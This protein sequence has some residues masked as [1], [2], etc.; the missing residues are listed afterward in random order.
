M[1][2]QQILIA[3][4]GGG[5]KTRA[6]AFDRS[7]RALAEKIAGPSNHLGNERALVRDSLAEVIDGVLTATGRTRED[8][9]T[10]S[11]GYAGVD[12]DGN[13]ED[14]MREILAEIGITECV[15]RG[16]MVIAHEGALRGGSGV[17]ALAGTGASYLGRSESGEVAKLGGWGYLFGDE[18]SAYWIGASALRAVSQQQDGRGPETLLTAMV[19]DIYGVKDFAQ[20]VPCVYQPN[21]DRRDIACLSRIV[22]EAAEAGD[23]VARR[24]LEEAG[25]ELAR[26]AEALIHRL[27]IQSGCEVSYQGS[28]LK[29]GR[30]VRERFEAALKLSVPQ[31][32]VVAPAAPPVYGAYS[33]GCHAVGWEVKWNVL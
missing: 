2:S 17:L 25:D 15:V 16:D 21:A 3:I 10:V 31:A 19:C 28:V 32:R 14:A 26:G 27:K 33:I 30:I 23:A 18:G 20:V 22:S 7:G 11:G 13:G 4:D 24:I 8:V 6:I 5:T 29:R 1:D 12:Y 9:C